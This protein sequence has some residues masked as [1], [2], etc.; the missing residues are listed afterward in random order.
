VTPPSGRRTNG[1]PGYGD[2]G[3]P[4]GLF[5]SFEGIEGAGK[6]TQAERLAE[7]LRGRGR[8]VVSVREPGG[9]ALGEDIRAALLAHRPGG[10]APWC[11]LCLYMASRAQ[12]VR[13]VVRP[14]LARGAV[15]I[16][17]RFAESSLAYQG[18]GRGLGARPVHAL[19]GW[20]TEGLRPDPVFLLD[21]D[22]TAGLSRIVSARGI[23]KLDRLELEPILFHRRVRAAYRRMVRREPDRFIVLDAALGVDALQ[24]RIRARVLVLLGE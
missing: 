16:A 1:P 12:L 13:E 10:M 5:L 21:L 4:V 11:E 20:V 23:S 3:G 18:G 14:A 8:E 24:D 2:S 15:I 17:D 7:W 22:P 6:T 19:Y 9:T